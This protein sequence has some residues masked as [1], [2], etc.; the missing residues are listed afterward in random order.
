MVFVQPN[1]ELTG[2]LRQGSLADRRMMNLG[3]GRPG[4]PAV[5]RPVERPVR[6]HSL[7]N[8]TLP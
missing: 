5:A 8:K 2:A 4:Y 1:E 7:V 6:R 3:A